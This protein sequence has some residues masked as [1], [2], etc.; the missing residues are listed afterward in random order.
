M[1]EILDLVCL[2]ACLTV[3]SLYQD[4]AAFTFYP[5]FFKVLYLPI[6]DTRSQLPQNK[7]VKTSS[8]ER[9]RLLYWMMRMP[10]FTAMPHWQQKNSYVS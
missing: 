3:H 6:F 7:F 4:H 8:A 9:T 5:A 2:L 1:D 10:S